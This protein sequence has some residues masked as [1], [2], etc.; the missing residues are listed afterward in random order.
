MA[1]AFLIYVTTSL[2]AGAPSPSNIEGL[3]YMRPEVIGLKPFLLTQPE[4]IVYSIVFA[5]GVLQSSKVNLS[6]QE[7]LRRRLIGPRCNTR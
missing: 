3:I 5:I 7:N 2:A 1:L 4:M 6:C